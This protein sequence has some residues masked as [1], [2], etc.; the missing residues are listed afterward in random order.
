MAATAGC[1]EGAADKWL[2]EKMNPPP[3]AARVV[4]I[5]SEKPDVRREALIAVAADP[6][7]RAMPSV[8]KL[9]CMVARNRGTVVIDPVTKV[10]TEIPTDPM[11]RAA[12]V[13]GLTFM[14]GDGVAE[15]LSDVLLN[16]KNEFVRCD[17]AKALGNRIPAEGVTALVE[18]LK[19]DTSQDVRVAAAESLRHFQD[20]VAAEALIAVVQDTNIA[21]AFRSWESLRYMTGQNLPREAAPWKDYLA[22]AENPFVAYGKAPP[23]P[24]GDNQRPVLTKGLGD[25]LNGLFQKDIRQAELE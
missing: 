2:H 14:D 24:P 12:A 13:R 18:A 25:F 1:Q 3:T 10:R 15:S 11:V 17:A 22:A 5:E 16:D 6:N 7:A 20:K 19:N 9:Y 4:E 8:V 23:I 21:I